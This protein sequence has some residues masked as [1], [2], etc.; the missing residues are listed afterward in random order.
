MTRAVTGVIVGYLVWSVLWLGGNAVFFTEAG[1]VVGGGERYAVVAA[2]VGAIALS[3]VCSIA[4]GFTAA[5]IAKERGRVAVL[6][7]AVLL[8]ATGVAVQL[9]VWALMPAWYHLT[10]LIL[11]VP[12]CMLGGR[13]ADRIRA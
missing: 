7:V 3:L 5:T 1:N 12:V 11:I 8:L 4:A 10:F 6:V 2:L 13:I 9:G